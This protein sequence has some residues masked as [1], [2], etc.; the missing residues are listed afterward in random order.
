MAVLV[1][2]TAGVS[3]A[4]LIHVPQVGALASSVGL[5]G[6]VK[7]AS[8]KRPGVEA[9]IAGDELPA[10]RVGRPL[11]R[12]PQGGRLPLVS[13]SVAFLEVLAQLDQAA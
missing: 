9:R 2:S 10:Q 11:E 13:P 7:E 3:V 6:G 5:A 8:R 12:R 1:G 4:A